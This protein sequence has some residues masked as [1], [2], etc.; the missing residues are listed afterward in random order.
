[1]FRPSGDPSMFLRPIYTIGLDLFAL[2]MTPD[3]LAL[4]AIIFDVFAILCG[5]FAVPSMFCNLLS[6]FSGLLRFISISGTHPS[7]HRDPQHSTS[8]F[9][10]NRPHTSQIRSEPRH[11]SHIAPNTRYIAMPARFDRLAPRF[12]P[13][14]PRE[15]R[16]YLADLEEYLTQANIEEE[17]E[18]K[19]YACRFWSTQIELSHSRTSF[20]R[21]IGY[22]PVQMDR[23]NG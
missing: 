22:I 11:T 7:T 17:Q 1:M 4:L 15:L 2:P 23:G 12:D 21:F 8:M 13:N 10:P 16:R 3:T 19:R 9:E 20:L 18:K 14:R 5:R 6:I